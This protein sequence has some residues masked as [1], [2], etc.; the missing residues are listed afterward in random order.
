MCSVLLMVEGEGGKRRDEWHADS[1]GHF[2][3]IAAVTFQSLTTDN[4]H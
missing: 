1:L 3:D 2:V 4:L